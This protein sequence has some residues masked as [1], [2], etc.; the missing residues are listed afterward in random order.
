MLLA[1]TLT[2]AANGSIAITGGALVV[3]I[4]GS[5]T[6]TFT[7]QASGGVEVAA[8][9]SGSSDSALVTND[10]DFASAFSSRRRLLNDFLGRSHDQECIFLN[11]IL[12][13]LVPNAISPPGPFNAG[14]DVAAQ[15]STPPPQGK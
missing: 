8:T 12:S 14:Q 11:V 13:N 6:V 10:V 5:T 4:G 2:Q 3:S 9:A 7:P 15:I 1:G